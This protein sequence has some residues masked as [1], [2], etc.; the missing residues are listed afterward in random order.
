MSE[1]QKLQH[2]GADTLWHAIRKEAEALAEQEPT[3]GSFIH[4]T[5]LNHEHFS[6]AL[7]FHLAGTLS[8]DELPAILVRE[9]IEQIYADHPEVCKAAELDILAVYNRDA[10]CD[11]YLAP[12]LFFKGYQALQ[13]HR[14]AHLLWQAS[15]TILAFYIQSQCSRK[16]NVDTHP[17]AQIGHGILLDHASGVVIGETAVVENDVSIL[18]GVTLGGTGKSTGDRHPKIRR[19][20][21]IGAGAK[22]L[23]NIE[24]GE[25]AKIGAG[26]VVLKDVPAHTTIAGIPARIIKT[27]PADGTPAYSMDHSLDSDT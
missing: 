2:K 11:N 3:L 19:G 21:L 23:G 4:A 8:S 7:S 5:V 27:A 1:A 10:A 22:I 17:A 6:S 25:N 12:L 24:I 18:Q 13:S 14:I 16:F 26:S 20:V 15:R 9:V